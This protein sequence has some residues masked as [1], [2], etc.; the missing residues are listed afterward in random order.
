MKRLVVLLSL[1]I[2]LQACHQ[3][4]QIESPDI[5]I[6]TPSKPEIHASELVLPVKIDLEPIFKQVNKETPMVFTG[7]EEICEGTSYSYT[8]KRKTIEFRG[9]KNK[10]TYTVPASYS[11]RLNYCPKCTDLFDEKGNCI[12]PRLYASCGV[13][14]APRNVEVSYYTTLKLNNDYHIQSTTKLGAFKSIDPCKITVFNYDATDKVEKEVK[15]ALNDAA[16]EI[17]QMISELSIQQDI[18]QGIKKLKQ[19]IDLGTLGKLN[20][21]ISDLSLSP[22]KFDKKEVDVDIQVTAFPVIGADTSRFIR[23]SNSNRTDGFNVSVPVNISYDSINQILQAY[24]GG[25]EHQIKKKVIRIDSISV[26][27]ANHNQLNLRLK[28]S[29]SKKGI[30]YLKGTPVIADQIIKLKDV[31]LTLESKDLLLKSARWIFDSK[32]EKEIERK[33]QFDLKKDINYIQSLADKYLNQEIQPG[34]LLK[35]T[36]HSIAVENL[37]LDKEN[38]NV[39]IHLQGKSSVKVSLP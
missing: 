13:D 18:E 15:T 3:L 20:L 33:F 22:F 37:H 6:D 39:I 34:I 2:S 12:V 27:G 35:T 21:N 29:G 23:K 19:P 4:K 30:I 17:D 1:S 28:F 26:C 10:L 9:E 25:T 5:V 38:A 11:I 16:E 32:I 36:L 8:F 14:E 24:F 31:Q 7:K